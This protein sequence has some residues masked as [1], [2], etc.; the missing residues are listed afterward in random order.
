MPPDSGPPALFVAPI[1]ELAENDPLIEPPLVDEP[2]T[3]I[4]NDD[5][6]EPP[7]REDADGICREVDE[8]P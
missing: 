3:G 2:I 8:Q 7:C 1:I 6:W 4:G 5:L